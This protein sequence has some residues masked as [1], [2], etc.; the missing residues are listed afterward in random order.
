VQTVFTDLKKFLDDITDHDVFGIEN[1]LIPEWNKSWQTNCPFD[2]V[3]IGA[4]VEKTH[5]G[6]PFYRSSVRK[7]AKQ[8]LSAK[9][10]EFHS[11]M[12]KW[13]VASTFNFL[14][15]WQKTFRN[16]ID[17]KQTRDAIHRMVNDVQVGHKDDGKKLS[18]A[19]MDQ[20]R[21]ELK[22][23]AAWNREITTVK[24][25][26]GDV[27]LNAK[28]DDGRVNEVISQGQ[29]ELLGIA[30]GMKMIRVEGLDYSEKLFKDKL[31]GPHKFSVTFAT[32]TEA[33]SCGRRLEE[34]AKKGINVMQE[35]MTRKVL[36]AP[37]RG[38]AKQLFENIIVEFAV[39][40]TTNNENSMDATLGPFVEAL[41]RC[42]VVRAIAANFAEKFV[43]ERLVTFDDQASLLA[44]AKAHPKDV[45]FALVFRNADL[46]GNFPGGGLEVDYAIRTH[47]QFLPSTSKIIRL[48]RNA[49]FGG[50]DESTYPYIM[51]YF[52]HLQENL[53]RA[54]ARLRAS[55]S[56]PKEY[57]NIGHNIKA[58]TLTNTTRKL[59]MALRQF[60]A[61]AYYMDRFM[62]IIQ[63]SMP[64]IFILGWIYA[65]SLLV[66]EIVYEK[67]EQLRDVMR[68]QGLKTWVYWASWFCSAMA[69]MFTLSCITT[70]ILCVG[71]VLRHSNPLVILT[72]FTIFSMSTVSLAM[73]ISSFF[74][75]AKVAAACAGIV[76][77]GLYFP[78]SMFNRFEDVM[79]IHG[80]NAL[81]LMS[82]TGMGIGAA[83]ISKWELIDE[84]AQWSNVAT[85]PPVT[86]S[87]A[88]PQDNF[89]LAHVMMMLLIDTVLYQVLAWYIE[90]VYPG[91]L[92]LPQPFYFPLLPSYWF[93]TKWEPP[94]MLANDSEAEKNGNEKMECY[95]SP[96]NGAKAMVKI[97]ELTKVFNKKKKAL[98]GITL[99]MHEGTIIGLLGHNG[100]GKSTTM[101]ILTGLYPPTA[102]D[103]E[104]NGRSVRKDS[105][106]VR[107]QL[108][109]CLQ[110]NALYENV[111]VEEHLN[112]FC[113]LKSVPWGQIKSSV[114]SLLTET[115][116]TPKR[117]AASRA[118]SGGMKRKL[119]KG[120]PFSGGSKDVTLD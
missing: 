110:T 49:V 90:K 23:G 47:S 10:K 92:G 53:G 100:A 59:S 99:D 114:D 4:K 55:R 28:W 119:T 9:V 6:C 93:G 42:P 19:F 8:D 32:P 107:Q 120:K 108:G 104:V 86:N 67:Q 3:A 60:P 7:L 58:H 57:T 103:V 97:R 80:K 16:H 78:Y 36:V 102:G 61:P 38:E 106:G 39:S 31:A 109:V 105:H 75:R 118:L 89:S 37:Y 13:N 50:V 91:T 45:L 116:L 63:H 56:V 73:F 112:L 94:K 41:G 17:P 24:F 77:W 74:S 71:G 52:A 5:N 54:V 21:H 48:S 76:Y 1:K 51:T 33:I 68:I 81:C 29:A 27:G 117:H 30:P 64:M 69:Q 25:T 111:T 101:A 83:L 20:V 18:Q 96:P 22:T 113:C 65:I 85:R 72:F 11:H 43:K 15:E 26:P 87:G 46:N 12:A 2:A 82:S 70:F 44:Y 88:A 79:S 14:H 66:K 95:E 84:G 34:R 98:K 35:L 115:G 40:L 62:R